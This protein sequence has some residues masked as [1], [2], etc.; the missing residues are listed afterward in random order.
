LSP[1]EALQQLPEADQEE[2]E[3]RWAAD[4]SNPANKNPQPQTAREF[5]DSRPP[6]AGIMDAHPLSRNPVVFR[7]DYLSM[8]DAL[9][10]SE[11][12]KQTIR[13]WAFEGAAQEI[14]KETAARLDAMQAAF[15]LAPKEAKSEA[16]V[17]GVQRGEGENTL[18]EA[19]KD[20][21][22]VREPRARKARKG[23]KVQR[24][25]ARTRKDAPAEGGESA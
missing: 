21:P 15:G 12:R 11:E 5:V 14:M 16:D 20:V 7:G 10:I 23:R 1:E 13:M 22:P 6:V 18:Q 8:I 24:K 19:S 25:V 17:Q 9:P 3:R 4:P 2:L